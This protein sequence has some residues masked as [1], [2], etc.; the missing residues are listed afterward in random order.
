LQVAPVMLPERAAFHH[1]VAEGK[2]ASEIGSGSKAAEDV[3][4]LWKWVS[5]HANELARKPAS[6]VAE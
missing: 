2:V 4:R 3:V 6:T 5:K 1:S